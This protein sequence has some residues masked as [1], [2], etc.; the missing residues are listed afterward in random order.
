MDSAVAIQDVLNAPPP[1]PPPVDIA[2]PARATKRKWRKWAEQDGELGFTCAPTCEC[3]SAFLPPQPKPPPGLLCPLG[4]LKAKGPQLMTNGATGITWEKVTLTV[5]SSASDTVIPPHYLRWC[6][7][8]H[9]EKVGTEYEVA[10]GENVYNIGERRCIMRMAETGKATEELEIAFQVV[11]D[12][13]KPLLAVSAITKQ[14]H[15]VVFAEEIPT[16]FR[17]PVASCQ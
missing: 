7:I 1:P 17:A 4:G 6:E 16:S 10:N 8:S 15:S 5:D 14:G 9:T 12:V 3:D 2:R 11:E 13:H